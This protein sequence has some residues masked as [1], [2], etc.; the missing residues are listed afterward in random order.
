MSPYFSRRARGFASVAALVP[1][2]CIALG[3]CTS[4]PDEVWAK[5]I[6]NRVSFELCAGVQADQVRVALATKGEFSPELMSVWVARGDSFF[7][8]GT[9][10]PYGEI[11]G[12]QNKIGPD[13]IDTSGNYIQIYVEHVSAEGEVLDSIFAQF[14]GDKLEHNGWLSS[15][16]ELATKACGS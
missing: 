16:G 8:P 14:D 4:P 11:D 9:V 3:G 12:F 5:L 15:S 1:L 13:E 7:Q 6:D 10:V 2:V